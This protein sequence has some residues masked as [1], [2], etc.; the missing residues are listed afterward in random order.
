MTLAEIYNK[1]NSMQE[2]QPSSQKE[3]VIHMPD[4]AMLV[5]HLDLLLTK[6]YMQ[7]ENQ[8]IMYFNPGQG[9]KSQADNVN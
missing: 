5:Q 9:S 4:V 2:E 3:L 8:Q 6:M 7:D 1:Q